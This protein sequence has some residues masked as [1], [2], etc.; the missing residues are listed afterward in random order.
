M[1]RISVSSCRSKAMRAEAL[2]PGAARGVGVLRGRW[3]RGLRTIGSDS[4]NGA[5]LVTL[6]DDRPATRRFQ[7]R[8][9]PE[10]RGSRS[11]CLAFALP[12]HPIE[13]AQKILIAD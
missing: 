2:R 12:L 1:P 6:A 5:S 11:S 13:G 7:V 9:T 10:P 3:T 4:L 8:S